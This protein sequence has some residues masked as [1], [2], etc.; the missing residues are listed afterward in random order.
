LIQTEQP[1]SPAGSGLFRSLSTW[2]RV[3]CLVGVAACRFSTPIWPYWG[4]AADTNGDRDLRRWCGSRTVI[5]RPMYPALGAPDRQTAAG[6]TDTGERN[7]RATTV[8]ALPRF[9][10]PGGTQGKGCWP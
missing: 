9:I 2:I 3:R 4:P 10:A 1:R 5:K 8:P 6:G 7:P